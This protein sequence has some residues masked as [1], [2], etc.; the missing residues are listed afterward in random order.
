MDRVQETDQH[1]REEAVNETPQAFDEDTVEISP[2]TISE[3]ST[4]LSAEEPILTN[5]QPNEDISTDTSAEEG[6]SETTPPKRR[7]RTTSAVTRTKKPRSTG[8]KPSQRGF[9]WPTQE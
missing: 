8:P 2:A 6:I 7:T 9:K 5:E 4:T 1:I 3:V